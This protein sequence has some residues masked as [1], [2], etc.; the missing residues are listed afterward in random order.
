MKPL[1]RPV[2]RPLLAALLL[3]VLGLPA[4]GGDGGKKG[5][6]GKPRVAPDLAA[7]LQLARQDSPI[8]VVVIPR[9]VQNRTLA[10]IADQ[11][12]G[13]GSRVIG[14]YPSVN[15]IVVETPRAMMGGVQTMS[16][17]EYLAPDRL[18]LGLE[19]HI[20]ETTGANLALNDVEATKPR[21]A[22]RPLPEPF[23]GQGV[24]VAILDSGID[25]GV[26]DLKDQ[27]K[28]RKIFDADFTD[29]PEKGDV[30]GHGT[31][32]AGIVSAV[33]PRKDQVDR[34]HAGIAPE[35]PLLNLRV[36]DRFGRGSISS[37]V[38]AIDFAVANKDALGIRVL[39]LSLAAPPIESYR[40]DPLCRAVDRA[41]A[42]G[43]T[44]VA[45]AGNFGLDVNGNEVYGGVTSPGNCP[46]AIT[47][48]AA[49]TRGTDPRSDDSVAL[50]SSRGPTR[51]HSTDPDTGKVVYDDLSKPDLVAPGVRI[52][53]V[54][55][56]NNLIVRSY[57]ELHVDTWKKDDKRRYMVLSGTS[58]STAVVSGAA[59]LVLQAN[60]G[61]PP[62]LVKAVLMYSAQILDGA[63]LFEQGAGLLNI[64]G[65]VRLARALPAGGTTTPDGLLENSGG[66]S[67]PWTTIEAERFGWSQGLI[68]GRGWVTGDRLFDGVRLVDAQTLIWGFSR[69]H[70]R[71]GVVFNEGLFSDDYV[72]RGRV[73]GWRD[74]SWDQGALMENGLLVRR[75]TYAYG[76]PWKNALIT[77][78]F[79]T[80]D[81]SGLIWGFGRSGYDSSLIW[82][83][84]RTDY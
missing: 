42:A 10:S 73:G 52:V 33:A 37:V 43:I 84:T 34:D 24:G 60:P 15:L 36:L 9:R 14:V 64:E 1:S 77:E 41:T 13:M 55:S 61:L 20:R 70:W 5:K 46:S 32:V 54:E 38:A 35:A 75:E 25:K 74:I 79:F 49:D 82:G 12:G 2:S 17:I 78:A 28:D 51:S 39:N 4:A 50:F 62:A 76:V 19:S 59:A 21:K 83:L 11:L 80:L 56:R 27:G 63:D 30:Y 71:R 7:I 26:P 58:Q 68:W 40:D 16:E 18:V 48:G 67:D 47:V 3:A 29:A 72:V 44:V 53:S 65:A 45:A 23:D 6:S 69:D 57:P 31:H 81:P 22:A 66:L 8:R